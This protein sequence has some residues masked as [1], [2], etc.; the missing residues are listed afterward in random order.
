VPPFFRHGTNRRLC[1]RHDYHAAYLLG[2]SSMST[3]RLF[4]ALAAVLFGASLRAVEQGWSLN[5]LSATYTVTVTGSTKFSDGHVSVSASVTKT[6]TTAIWGT[7]YE[8][9]HNGATIASG[10]IYYRDDGANVSNQSVVLG[11]LAEGDS[12]WVAGWG[13]DTNSHIQNF[14]PQ[15]A[16]VNSAT[17]TYKYLTFQL[18]ANT[19][20]NPI[21]YSVV[22][23]STGEVMDVV[24]L[25]PGDP[26]GLFVVEVPSDA[27]ATDF[28][29]K[30]YIPS[31]KFDTAGG[32]WVTTSTPGTETNFT[33]IDG[34]AP[35]ATAEANIT[36]PKFHTTPTNAT[37][38]QKIAVPTPAPVPPVAVDTATKG[39]AVW[40]SIPSGDGL[41]DTRFME[42]IDK[43]VSGQAE[44]TGH[45]ST[46][47]TGLTEAKTAGTGANGNIP[48]GIGGTGTGQGNAAVGNVKAAYNIGGNGTLG[49]VTS[50]G[51]GSSTGFQF[52]IFS[53]NFD[54]DPGSNST[55]VKVMAWIKA[56]LAWG[57]TIWYSLWVFNHFREL[58]SVGAVPQIRGHDIA[59]GA[60]GQATALGNAV[61]WTTIMLALPV[62]FTA[63]MSTAGLP[64]ASIV[65]VLTSPMPQV[66]DIGAPAG[67]ALK[68]VDYMLPYSTL[69]TALV[70]RPI[71]SA[72]SIPIYM[73][74]QTAIR[75]LIG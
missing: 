47:A 62:A 23:T 3:F 17:P 42:G 6:G 72:F 65:S 45:L 7:S 5:G 51:S 60:G 30:F 54:F 57:I 19:G 33:L 55:L 26:A 1:V 53:F 21:S 56:L 69:V 59:M 36:T 70:A 29:L 18:P 9:R 14:S 50:I 27:L 37:A 34:A 38:D 22:R 32:N 25:N 8:K 68:L 16:F 58:T 2:A 40:R 35:G 46:L 61:V 24:V 73:S 41:T 20:K 44:Q 4:I 66:A 10:V 15:L 52:A 63:A 49:N 64:M 31:L 11:D 75:W 28:K 39:G 12:V 71:I 67:I 74:V 13:Q 48:G 43:V